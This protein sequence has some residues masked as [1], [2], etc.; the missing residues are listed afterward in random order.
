VSDFSI[1]LASERII[2]QR[3][4]EH[5]I[6][7]SRSFSNECF[8]SSIVM[9]W[10]VVICD[11]TYKLQTLRDMYSDAGAG[12]LLQDVEAKRATNPN[13]PDWELFLLDEIFKR[14]QFLE[15]GEHTQLQGVQKLRH[16]SAHPVVTSS[17]LLFSP[18]K[19]AV[20][21]A[22]RV[23]MEAVLL[24]PPLFSKK[25]VG[26][27]LEDIA[28]NKDILVAKDSLKRYIEARYLPNMQDTVEKELFRSLWKFCFKLKNADT[29]INRNINVAAL[30]VIYARK[31]SS[32]RKQIEQD[33]AY[34]SDISSDEDIVRSLLI[35][36]S[37]NSGIYN[38]LMTQQ[39]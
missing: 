8:R 14:T 37:E 17:S 28:S 29:D 35:F 21:A 9:L 23:A 13:S 3:T 20:R 22:I 36:L 30:S 15:V 38:I 1:D 10:S 33:Q 25:I 34:F 12:R 19:E 2:D 7:V 26:T 6:E 4:R 27:L 31:A 39:K 18:T 32:F 11:L 16:L 24:K 5:F